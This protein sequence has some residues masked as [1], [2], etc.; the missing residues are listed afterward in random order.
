MSP[1]FL[2]CFKKKKFEATQQKV[3]FLGLPLDTAL[4]G[5][6]TLYVHASILALPELLLLIHLKERSKL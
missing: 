4:Q 6:H 1:W 5:Q 3:I 2:F